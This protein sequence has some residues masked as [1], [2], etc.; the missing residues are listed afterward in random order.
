MFLIKMRPR[1]NVRNRYLLL[2]GFFLI[3]SFPRIRA[4][5]RNI[6]KLNFYQQEII[7]LERENKILAEKLEKIKNDPFTIE[8]IGR[9]TY[10]LRKNG[11]YIFR[12]K[13]KNVSP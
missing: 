7:R 8:K 5:Y 13:D 4:L 9:E 12:I 10:G 1:R 6:K 3:I 2:L 11:E